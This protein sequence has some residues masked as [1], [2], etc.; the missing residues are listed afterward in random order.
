MRADGNQPEA[1]R[2]DGETL[3]LRIP[4]RFQ[5]HG[6]RKLIVGPDGEENWA[7]LPTGPDNTLIRALGRAHRWKRL[8]ENGTY[9]SIKELATAEK[10]NDTYVGRILRLTLLAPDVVEVILDGRQ[11]RMLQL[12]DL[13]RLVSNDWSEQRRALGFRS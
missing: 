13:M 5:R 12:K 3:T 1:V 10:V 9:G 11:P 8:I 7:P 2:F 4:M 6:G